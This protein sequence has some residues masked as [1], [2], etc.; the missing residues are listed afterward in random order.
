MTT[1][2]PPLK[3]ILLAD[4]G[5]ENMIS[6]VKFLSDIPGLEGA[7]VVSLRVFTPTE[8]SEYARIERESQVTKNYLK[9]R[10]FHFSAEA[11][12]GDP[13]REIIHKAEAIQPDLIVMGSKATGRF[14]G[15]LG[16]VATEVTH[17]GKWPVLIVKKP[18]EKLSKVLLA[19]DG[20]EYSTRTAA[21]LNAFPLKDPCCVTVATIG[22]PVQ[23]TYPIE[24]AG[25]A[26]AAI[27]PAEE[28]RMNR[29]NLEVAKTTVAGI[30]AKMT[31]FSKVDTI[32]KL[33]DPVEEILAILESEPFDL[34]V[35]GSR[36]HGNLSGW[37]LGS[38]SRSLVR[39]APSSV[40]VF[41]SG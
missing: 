31:A 14:G 3:T 41:R 34:L 29:E 27:S 12:L 5:T 9:S 6:A 7:A 2:N 13:V 28:E 30:A 35:C 25:M 33:G 16:N 1:Q 22:Q 26:L 17:A 11:I 36:G 37:L 21:Y 19:V 23:V 10:H 8:G 40:L 20:S 24:P 32:A 39:A 38:V 18:Y 4:D 15:L